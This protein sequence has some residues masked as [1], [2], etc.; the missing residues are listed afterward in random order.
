[1][2]D[3]PERC[4]GSGDAGPAYTSLRAQTLGP[5]SEDRLQCVANRCHGMAD[6]HRDRGRCRGGAVVSA[7]RSVSEAEGG[8]LASGRATNLL[9]RL[10]REYGTARPGPRKGLRVRKPGVEAGGPLGQEG[11]WLGRRR[12]AFLPRSHD[13]ERVPAGRLQRDRH[14]RERSPRSRQRRTDGS[15]NDDR[16][17]PPWS[18]RVKDRDP[19]C[20]DGSSEDR[21][22]FRR[23]RAV[24]SRR[25]GN[26]PG[27]AAEA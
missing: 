22:G 19:G 20:R 1:M 9:A 5:S 21:G 18:H 17:G 13:S 4:Q 15:P 14:A 10:R 26:A 27:R 12:A 6:R 23:W 2:T 24:G 8:A 7:P 25:G 3:Q 16:R 11:R